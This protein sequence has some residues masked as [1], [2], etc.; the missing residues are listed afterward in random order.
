ML[1]NVSWVSYWTFIALSLLLYY[2]FI[3]LRFLRVPGIS[4]AHIPGDFSRANL[5]DEV[6]AFLEA[7]E[8]SENNKSEIITGLQ[9]LLKKYQPIIQPEEKGA[10]LEWICTLCSN[11]YAVLLSEKDMRQV[12]LV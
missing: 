4:T 3:W 2:S 12:W 10:L 5:T 9:Q 8:P 6:V 1:N 11:K 7:L